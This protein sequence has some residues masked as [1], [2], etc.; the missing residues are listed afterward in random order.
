MEEGRTLRR[1]APIKNTAPGPPSDKTRPCCRP[2]RRNAADTRT[3]DK[4]MSILVRGLSSSSI[5]KLLRVT[6]SCAMTK[7]DG[8]THVRGTNIKGERDGQCKPRQSSATD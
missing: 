3:S 6:H 4:R 5:S 2:G 7:R 8:L 1:R